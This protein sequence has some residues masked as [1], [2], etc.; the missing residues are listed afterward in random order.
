MFNMISG[1]IFVILISAQLL[2]V[3][4][5][6]NAHAVWSAQRL[7]EVLVNTVINMQISYKAEE[8]L[9][10]WETISFSRRTLIHVLVMFLQFYWSR[11]WRWHYF[12]SNTGDE[13]FNVQLGWTWFLAWSIHTLQ[14]S[15]SFLQCP[16]FTQRGMFDVIKVFL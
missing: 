13:T 1:L 7:W 4:M 3:G 12:V 2:N 5:Y 9:T 8:L 10:R 6:T 16:S 11:V 15:C 14:T